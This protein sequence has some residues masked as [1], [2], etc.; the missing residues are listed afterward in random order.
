[1][2]YG[3]FNDAISSCDYTSQHGM[4]WL[5]N[6]ELQRMWK[7]CPYLLGILSLHLPG[8]E[9]GLRK[10]MTILSHYSRLRDENWTWVHLTTQHEY[11][12]FRLELELVEDRNFHIVL[13]ECLNTWVTD[14]VKAANKKWDKIWPL[15][16]P[17]PGLLTIRYVFYCPKQS[18]LTLP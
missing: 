7:G 18:V 10:L 6:G 12:L 8:G 9:G 16:D 13:T 4:V 1:L 14:W 11:R 3:L 5:V 2:I 15:R 17:N